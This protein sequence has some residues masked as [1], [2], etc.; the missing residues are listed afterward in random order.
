MMPGKYDP[1]VGCSSTCARHVN[2]LEDLLSH[3]AA[4][5]EPPPRAEAKRPQRE[6]PAPA[7]PDK[8]A[9]SIKE[10]IK[11]AE[12]SRNMRLTLGPKTGRM[13]SGPA[14]AAP[15]HQGKSRP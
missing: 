1:R 5:A 6:L 11:L 9:Y 13:P 7:I 4:T 3:P 12:L 15:L 8:L 10:V 14:C 2:I